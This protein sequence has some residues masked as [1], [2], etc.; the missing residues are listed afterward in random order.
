ML[1]MCIYVCCTSDGMGL[2]GGGGGG[3]A[4]KMAQGRK[5][6]GIRLGFEGVIIPSN[7]ANLSVYTL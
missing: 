1:C 7:Y 4:C 2:G 6:G 5:C 3:E